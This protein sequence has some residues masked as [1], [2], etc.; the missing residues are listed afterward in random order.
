MTMKKIK[1]PRTYHLPWSDGLTGDDRII[2]SLDKFIDKDVVVTIKYDGESFT[3]YKDG[4]IHARSLDTDIDYSRT[5]VKNLWNSICYNLPDGYRVC[6]ENLTYMHSIFYKNL[7]SYLLVHSIWDENNICLSWEDTVVY[8]DLLGLKHVDVL[9]KGKFDT[10][11]IKKFCSSHYNE[12][13]MEGYVIRLVDKF[14]YNEFEQC[15]AKFVRKNHHQTDESWNPV[16]L[17]TLKS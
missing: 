3:G 13:E 16:T 11:L 9:Y 10:E 4:Y 2:D 12:N 1:Y 14:H 6:A 15:V 5:F 17:N 7:E 8:C